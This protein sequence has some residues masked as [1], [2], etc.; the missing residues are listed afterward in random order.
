MPLNLYRL[1]SADCPHKSKGRSY[2]RCNCRI[3]A[4]GVT[5]DGRAI[6]T[7]LKTRAW[8]EAEAKARELDRGRAARIP[9]VEEAANSFL[10]DL[11]RRRLSV[12][13]Q[14]KFRRML[15]RLEQRH[16]GA[17]LDQLTTEDMRELA[18]SWKFAASTERT[19]IERLR[20]FWRFC[21]ES[22]W[23]DRNPAAGV[24]PP[25]QQAPQVQPFT[26]GEMGAILAACDPTERAFCLLMRYSGLRIVDVTHMETNRIHGDVLTLRTQ[27]TGAVVSVPLPPVV[28]RALDEFPHASELHY[29]WHGGSFAQHSWGN[30]L[31]RMFDRSGVAGAHSHRFRHTFAAELLLSGASLESVSILL[32]HAS[33]KTTEKH[34]AAWIRERQDK[35]DQQVRRTWEGSK[36]DQDSFDSALKC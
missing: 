35:L 12:A 8:A 7:S 15:A 10:K 21:I 31:K 22:G 5:S 26:A 23:A 3:W 11:E 18:R 9:R 20:Q 32:G 33:I 28:L 30:R 6:K 24:K 25:K 2:R 1:H 16:P 34:Y 17:R 27:K 19:E 14:K 36:L 4:Q 29:F 13:V